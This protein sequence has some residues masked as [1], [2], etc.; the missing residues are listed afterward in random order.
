[1]KETLRHKKAFEYYLYLGEERSYRKVAEAFKVSDRAVKK[2]GTEFKWSERLYKREKEL[3]DKFR[4]QNEDE[5]LKHQKK[6]L[7][8]INRAIEAFEK[9]LR[10]KKYQ[11]S[12]N[13][14]EKLIKLE[15][16]LLGGVTDRTETVNRD[17]ISD[18][19][20]EILGI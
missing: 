5:F 10:N 1:M 7:D 9:D 20:D 8:L 13:D 4:E 15:Q 3:A 11:L 16:L 2:W 18:E 17:E 6:R 14:L 12:V 19:I